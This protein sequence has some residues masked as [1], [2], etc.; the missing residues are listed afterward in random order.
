MHV[1]IRVVCALLCR[2]C[3]RDFIVL[4]LYGLAHEGDVDVCFFN[5]AVVF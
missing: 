1:T 3:C 2:L 5:N 4:L